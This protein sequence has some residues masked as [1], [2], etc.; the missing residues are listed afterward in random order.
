MEMTCSQTKW[1]VKRLIS[2]FAKLYLAMAD[3]MI[4]QAAVPKSGIYIAS[5]S[6]AV[7]QARFAQPQL[8]FKCAGP[9]CWRGLRSQCGEVSVAAS[10]KY[11]WTPVWCLL[12]V[13]TKIRDVV[14]LCSQR[15]KRQVQ[16]NWLKHAGI[17]TSQQEMFVNRHAFTCRKE[18]ASR[19]C[20]VWRFVL[21]FL[22][23]CCWVF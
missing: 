4:P 17:S 10:E 15:G 22:W 1:R 21:S 5:N 19:D 7:L 12:P 8:V 2:D 23:S 16:Q 20:Y 14:L 11:S 9:V 6:G 3:E 18:W 13:A